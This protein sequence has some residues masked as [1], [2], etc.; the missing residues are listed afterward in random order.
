M[1]AVLAGIAQHRVLAGDVGKAPEVG[2]ICEPLITLWN[3]VKTSP[4]ALAEEYRVRWE[5]LQRE[6]YLVYYEIR[7][8]FN[9]SHTPED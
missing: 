3:R 2:D 6:G 1:A 4:D 8:S 9:T 5:R 7:D